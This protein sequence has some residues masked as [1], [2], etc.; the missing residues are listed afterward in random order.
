M[1]G[2]EFLCARQRYI[3]WY[4]YKIENEKKNAAIKS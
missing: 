2:A 4:A 3:E 1:S